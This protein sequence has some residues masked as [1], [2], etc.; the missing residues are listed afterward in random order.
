[1]AAYLSRAANL[2]LFCLCCWVM[3]DAAN[4]VLAAVL[5]P[6]TA[7]A[8]GAERSLGRDPR[9]ERPGGLLRRRRSGCREELPG[10]ALC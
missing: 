2:V 5:L 10:H 8:A 1:M 9:R 7:D 3:A 4:A 6:P